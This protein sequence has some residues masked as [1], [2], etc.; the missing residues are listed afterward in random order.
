MKRFTFC[1]SLA[2]VAAFG[3]YAF[4][5]GFAP[6]QGAAAVGGSGGDHT[7][8][9][10]GTNSS[11]EVVAI[12]H[13]TSG[14]AAAGFGG[15]IAFD[16]E[17]AGGNLQAD[18]VKVEARYDTATNGSEDTSLAFHTMQGGNGYEVAA[19]TSMGLLL[20]PSDR[21]AAADERY[22]LSAEDGGS[23]WIYRGG[24][25]GTAPYFGLTVDLDDSS[26]TFTTRD[27]TVVRVD[28]PFR[29]RRAI[30]ASTAGSGSPN[31]LTSDESQLYLSNEGSSAQNYHT[32]PS[33]IAGLTYTFLV[34][35]A[36]GIRVTAASGDTI[37]LSEVVSAS[38]GY[39]Q[40]TT[41]GSAITLVA[42]N[43]TEWIATEIC[44]TWSVDQ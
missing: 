44:G 28:G 36:D 39:V 5:D 25:G 7:L 27:A 3:V 32:L 11:A 14:T 31:V 18:A 38:A 20:N 1:L 9:D 29:S 2:F 26:A 22:S 41:I 21:G 40:S 23:L 10:S 33:A 12:Q 16:L 42:V 15:H 24:E 37:R 35:D 6:P 13:D 34:Q 8:S 17:D 4:A 19:I 30:E 43:A